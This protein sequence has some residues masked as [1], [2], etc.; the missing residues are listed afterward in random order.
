MQYSPRLI[1]A[2]RRSVR[3]V[4][5]QHSVADCGITEDPLRTDPG[6]GASAAECV[7]RPAAEIRVSQDPRRLELPALNSRSSAL[8]PEGWGP[9]LDGVL[10]VGVGWTSTVIVFVVWPSSAVRTWRPAVDGTQYIWA[11]GTS[12]RASGTTYVRLLPMHWLL[13]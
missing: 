5:R 11:V 13:S 8:Q 7:P 4:R 12:T 1:L 6:S 3:A 10:P 9:G 2:G